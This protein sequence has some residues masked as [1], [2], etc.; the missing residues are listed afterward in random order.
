MNIITGDLSTP[1]K[2]EEEVRVPP[3]RKR[4]FCWHIRDYYTVAMTME[5]LCGWRCKDS[6]PTKNADSGVF[7]RSVEGSLGTHRLQLATSNSGYI[8]RHSVSTCGVRY[9]TSPHMQMGDKRCIV[10]SRV[11]AHLRVSTH[12]P[13][14]MITPRLFR[15]DYPT[16]FLRALDNGWP[17]LLLVCWQK[18]WRG[19]Q[20]EL[21][22]KL[23]HWRGI[24][25]Y[26]APKP[27]Q[28]I[29]YLLHSLS[30]STAQCRVRVLNLV[31]ELLLES[32]LRQRK[33]F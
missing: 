5:C 18:Y 3:H 21:V 25:S 23:E 17:N 26:V 22:P 15:F 24:L 28:V 31:Q 1:S 19:M 14:L 6:R 4:G 33:K 27:V 7:S 9:C 8:A 11:S 30:L 2:W 16:L 12:P 29:W 32:F 10:F 13:F 20:A